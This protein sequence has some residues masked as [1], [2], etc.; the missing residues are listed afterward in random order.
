M[1]SGWSFLFVAPALLLGAC[2]GSGGT[3][4]QTSPLCGTALGPAPLRRI[5]RFEYGHTLADLTG[6]PADV[7]ST[8]PPDEETLGFDDIASAYSVSGLH[9]ARYLDI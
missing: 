8:L 7:A 6:L 2:G 1:R 9:A 4:T 5:T 3:T